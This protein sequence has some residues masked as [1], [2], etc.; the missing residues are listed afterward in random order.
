[1]NKTEQVAAALYEQWAKASP[2][3]PKKW[4]DA[5][6]GLRAEFL[7][8]GEEA[9]VA[10]EAPTW[11]ERRKTFARGEFL[12]GL[13]FGVILTYWANQIAMLL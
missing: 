2:S 1:M 13:G 12:M 8:I 3:Q 7:G 10:Y 11:G 5:P 9:V 6:P 4:D